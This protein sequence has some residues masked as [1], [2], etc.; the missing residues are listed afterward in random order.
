MRNPK[1]LTG[2][3]LSGHPMDEYREAARKAKAAPMG[4]ILTDFAKE[5]GPETYRDDQRIT[6]AGIV[7][8]AKTKTTKNNSLM[9]YVT[10]E[11]DTGTMELLVFAR[12]LD[13]CGAYLKEGA[14][15]CVEGRLSV[16][17]EKS[18]QLLADTIRPLDES[19]SGAGAEPQKGERLYVKL[20]T[21]QDPVFEKIRRVFLMFPGEQQ[22]VFYFADTKKRVGASCLIHPALQQELSELLGAEN[23]IIK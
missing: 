1:S 2:L 14:A 7:S 11:D 20:P 8:A 15:L 9:A 22:A 3:Y 12:T 10:L 21:A 17:D 19:A 13:R 5:G 23:V 4:A 6:L 16:R 18:P